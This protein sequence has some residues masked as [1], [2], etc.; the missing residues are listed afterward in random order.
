MKNQIIETG[1][2]TIENQILKIGRRTINIASIDNLENIKLNRYPLTNRI[3]LGLKN[4]LLYSL[5]QDL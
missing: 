5:S 1:I 2:L 4:S 3:V